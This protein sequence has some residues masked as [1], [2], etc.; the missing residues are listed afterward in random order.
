MAL[1]SSVTTD[2]LNC[3]YRRGIEVSADHAVGRVVRY[4]ALITII[5]AK[6]SFAFAAMHVL[7]VSFSLMD[8]ALASLPEPLLTSIDTAYKGFL[9][10]VRIHVL[11]Q[12]L[13]KREFLIALGAWKCFL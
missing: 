13:L 3:V 12:V 6:V 7:V 1:V 2:A 5:V 9:S 11:R 4:R 8:T 10:R